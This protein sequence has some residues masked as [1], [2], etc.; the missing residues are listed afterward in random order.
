LTFMARAM[1]LCDIAAGRH[2][3]ISTNTRGTIYKYIPHQYN[4]T[5]WCVEVGA[6]SVA[7]TCSTLIARILVPV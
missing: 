5:P 4:T 3:Y 7:V 2:I 6:V 1:L